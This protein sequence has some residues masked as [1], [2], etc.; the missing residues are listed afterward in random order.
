M[1]L[2]VLGASGGTGR[3]VV[4]QAL[5]DGDEVVAVARAGSE[6]P[7]GATV[8][9]AE[10]SDVETLA[11]AVAGAD[12]VVSALGTRG[13]GPT[14]VCTDGVG[15]AIAAMRRTGVRRL[16]V[17]SAS[18]L[19]GEGDDAALRWLVKPVL[20]RILR[21]HYADLTRMD[22][23]VRASDLDWTIVRPP[24]LTDGPRTDRYRRALDRHVARGHRVARADLAAELLRLAREAGVDGAVGHLVAVAD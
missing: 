7:A 19:P 17:V 24:Q 21:H 22:E 5:A 1:R 23:I 10:I 13:R 4:T 3:E 12:A 20:Q 16:L 15:A 14:S 8:V 6:V 9:R 2:V 11:E 18:G